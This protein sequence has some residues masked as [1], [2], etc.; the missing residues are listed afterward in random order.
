MQLGQN[1]TVAGIATV[2]SA[3]RLVVNKP[4]A[5]T[6]SNISFKCD[7]CGLMFSHL[8][9]LN[10]HKRM[11]TESSNNGDQITVVSQGGQGLVQSQNLVNENGQSLGQI[12]IVATEALEQAQQAILQNSQV[13]LNSSNS[14][15]ITSA[16]SQSNNH[17][18]INSQRLT[19]SNS[20][21][22]KVSKCIT[23]GNLLSPSSRRKGTKGSRCA[24][25][26]S[27][28][29]HQR[30]QLNRSTQIFVAPDGEIKFELGDMGDGDVEHMTSDSMGMDSSGHSIKHN[31]PTASSS[32]IPG[33][34]PVKKRN[35]TAVTK[36]QKC[37]GSGVI[38]VGGQK[39]KPQQ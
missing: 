24:T 25:C 13:Q 31:A 26:L 7:V 14:T 29:N 4:I 1:G 23:C 5:N 33:H 3:G 8:T 30:Q 11:H 18:V 17:S 32:I 27:H 16:H 35:A 2:D 9:L 10:H 36:C 38:Y 15:I 19:S 28:D 34:Y 22:E 6:I 12:Q 39:Q 20:K 37:N 21:P